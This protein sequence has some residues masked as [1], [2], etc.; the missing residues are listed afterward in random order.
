MSRSSQTFVPTSDKDL[1]AG[2]W[3][4][5]AFSPTNCGVHAT[6]LPTQPHPHPFYL[7]VLVSP[8]PSSLRMSAHLP[9]SDHTEL[10][11]AGA[12]SGPERPA[13]PSH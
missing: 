2:P 1:M 12:D 8:C 6:H 11:L 10:I 5:P 4:G 9:I 13:S 3:H 7:P